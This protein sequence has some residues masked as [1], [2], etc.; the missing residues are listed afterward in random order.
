M[1]LSYPPVY[2]TAVSDLGTG[3][4]LLRLIQYL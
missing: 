2:S 4:Y 3:A 1:G